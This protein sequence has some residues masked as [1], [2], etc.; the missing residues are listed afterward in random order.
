MA[1]TREQLINTAAIL[2][3]TSIT[4]ISI[5]LGETLGLTILSGIGIGL[6]PII[7][8]RGAMHLKEKWL[9]STHGILN[10]DIQHA[11]VR[12]FI[13]A[14]GSLEEKYF[15]L[16]ETDQISKEKKEAIKSLFQELKDE[17]QTI[18]I[19]SIEKAVSSQ[20]IKS[21]LYDDPQKAKNELWERIDGTKLIYS[22][23]GEHFKDFLRDNCLD[24]VVFYFGLELKDDNKESN[25]AW[26]AFQ[27]MLLEGIQADV[28]AVKAGQ[29]EIK[30]DLK[31]LTKIKKQLDEI[32][33]T[34]DHRLPTEPFQ[35]S[36]AKALTEIQNALQ[37]V[38]KT[39]RRID[40][41]QDRHIKTTEGIA[42]D[43]K[44]LLSESPEPQVPKVPKN[45]KAVIDKGRGR[46]PHHGQGRV[47][48]VRERALPPVRRGAGERA[49][50]HGRLDAA[51][52]ALDPDEPLSHH[53][54]SH[55]V[56]HFHRVEC[57][58]LSDAHRRSA[59]ADGL[60]EGHPVLVGGGTLLADVGGGAG[61]FAR[62][63]LRRR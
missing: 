2:A 35:E 41:K 57:G 17:A 60:S 9:D 25:K 61:N 7:I 36:F 63:V 23:Y 33:D 26:R 5:A 58:R 62:P 48:A 31:I 19:D 4:G 51:D 43:V 1:I 21:Y 46:H 55:R 38:A 47:H 8:D 34:I 10:H 40:E 29:D 49:R 30:H 59:V 45:I 13:K 32:K 16:D 28:K 15:A 54:A 12:A 3:T 53:R 14:L 37:D 56:L 52:P 44:K 42:S 24:E 39:T 6:A 11:L 50:H 27:R 20:E 22:Y 18:F